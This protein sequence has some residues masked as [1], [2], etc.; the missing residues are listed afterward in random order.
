M[1]S[2]VRLDFE[3]REH[4]RVGAFRK[5]WG[6][7][8]DQVFED[9]ADHYDQANLFA[10]FGQ[11]DRLL[12]SFMPIIDPRPNERALDVCAG[13]NAVGIAMLEREPRLLS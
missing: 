13:T 11:W 5:V 7:H 12:D 6:Q 2:R 1:D 9:V 8:L 10:S 4:A 3:A